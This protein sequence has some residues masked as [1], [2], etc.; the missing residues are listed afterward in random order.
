MEGLRKWGGRKMVIFLEI[1]K[2]KLKINTYIVLLFRSYCRVVVVSARTCL[3]F[4][5]F[6][7]ARVCQKQGLIPGLNKAEQ[8]LG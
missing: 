1:V 4:L 8:G 3:R 5:F 6:N 7:S 2:I